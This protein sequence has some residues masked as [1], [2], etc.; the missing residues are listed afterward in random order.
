MYANVRFWPK[1]VVNPGSVTT[2]VW[3][4]SMSDDPF[5]IQCFVV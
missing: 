4:L 2:K 1:A 5:N 3:V